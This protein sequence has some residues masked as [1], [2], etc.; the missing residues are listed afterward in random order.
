MKKRFLLNLCVVVDI[1]DGF[2]I[3]C[4]ELVN[5]GF[6]C[7]CVFW[8]FCVQCGVE[9]GYVFYCCYVGFMI[10][11]VGILLVDLQCYVWVGVVW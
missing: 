10:G 4:V 5:V 8:C 1:I 6:Y 11:C 9:C 3:F 7:Y 2:D